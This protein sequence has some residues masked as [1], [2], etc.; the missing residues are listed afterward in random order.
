MDMSFLDDILKRAAFAFPDLT[1]RDKDAKYLL[2]RGFVKLDWGSY[3]K[4][5][6]LRAEKRVFSKMF[7]DIGDVKVYLDINT[8]LLTA[9]FWPAGCIPN[10]LSP[11]IS[12]RGGAPRSRLFWG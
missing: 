11:T 9:E 6:C 12:K 8:G 4:H 1:E 2:C 5:L 7:F 3:V 10:G